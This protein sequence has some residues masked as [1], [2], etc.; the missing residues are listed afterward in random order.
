M[1]EYHWYFYL[2]YSLFKYNLI[3]VQCVNFSVSWVALFEKSWHIFTFSFIKSILNCEVTVNCFLS[4]SPSDLSITKNKKVFIPIK[5]LYVQILLIVN[6]K[7][8]NCILWVKSE[9]KRNCVDWILVTSLHF[10][11]WKTSKY[12]SFWSS[13]NNNKILFSINIIVEISFI[14]MVEMVH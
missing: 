13:Y 9:D 4:K 12:I 3:K 8:F 11:S 7:V 1:L 14:K 6:V 5:W 2:F 10:W